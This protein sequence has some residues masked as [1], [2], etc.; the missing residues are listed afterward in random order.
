MVDSRGG[1]MPKS[2][3]KLEKEIGGVYRAEFAEI[4]R[5]ELEILRD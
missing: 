1:L 4:Q 5:S 2:K 3:I